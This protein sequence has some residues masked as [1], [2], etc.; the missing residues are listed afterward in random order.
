MRQ[1]SIK[2]DDL[3]TDFMNAEEIVALFFCEPVN[4]I[5]II[6]TS[7]GEEDFRVTLIV[8]FEKQKAVIKISSNGFSDE[9]HLVLWERLARQY[10]DLGYYCPQFIRALDGSYPKVQYEGRECIAWAEEYSKYRSAREL[11][12]EK[13]ADTHLVKD[14]WY[15]FLEDAMIM[16]AKV[17]ACHFDYTDLPSAYCMFELFDPNDETDET[18]EDAM[19]WLNVA[20]T[21]PNEFLER[22]EKIWNRWTDARKELEEI[23]HQLPTSVFQADINDTNVLLDESGNFKGVYDFNIGGK[24]VYINYIIRQAPYVSTWDEYKELEQEDVFLKRVLHALSI[25]RKVYVFT[26][27]EK[28]A[29]PLLYKCIRPLWWAASEELKEVGNDKDK[30]IRHL[31][32]VEF[33]QIREIDFS[34]YM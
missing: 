18:T 34:K 19:R 21:L 1:I 6:N 7:H 13:Y 23:Y 26:D 10:R 2:T 4:D 20:Q 16:D 5:N 22:V 25:A 30:I 28:K 15:S 11:I 14:G 3:S 27:L 33:E 31:D 9:R 8:T 17:A 24:E 29:A 12:K 32:K